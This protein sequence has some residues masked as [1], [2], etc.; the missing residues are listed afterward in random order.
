[1]AIDVSGQDMLPEVGFVTIE[2]KNSHPLMRL[3][4]ALQ[5]SRSF[6]I[7]CRPRPIASWRT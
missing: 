2:V 4:V 7:G 3:A 5:R 6:A 1:M